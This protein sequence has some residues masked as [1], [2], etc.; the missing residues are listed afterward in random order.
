[1]GKKLYVGNLP[2]S[3]NDESL[4]QYFS[5]VGTVETA[6]VIVDRQ[7]GRSKG[8]GFVEMSSDEE[9]Q[10]AIQELNG[11]DN[12]GRPITVSEARPQEPRERSGGFGGDRD[13]FSRGGGGGG[14]RF[15][16]GGGGGFRG[17]RY[18]E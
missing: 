3:I 5:S 16:R 6:K 18:S 15:S 11:K 17:D 2:F 13:R 9:A 4:H 1:M 10:K 14:G 12:N 7:T 8:Y